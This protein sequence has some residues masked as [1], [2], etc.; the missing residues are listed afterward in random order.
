MKGPLLTVTV[1][2]RQGEYYPG[3]TKPVFFYEGG[4]GVAQLIWFRETDELIA[5]VLVYERG[6]NSPVAVMTWAEFKAFYREQPG[7]D[8]A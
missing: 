5:R 4:Y 1:D 6:N 3:S 2:G 7:R 8:V